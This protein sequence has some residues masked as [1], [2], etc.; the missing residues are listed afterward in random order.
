MDAMASRNDHTFGRRKLLT[1][2]AALGA[3]SLVG[4]PARVAAEPPPETTRLR[5]MKLPAIC[6]APEYLA[7]DLLGLEGFTDVQYVEFDQ[8]TADPLLTNK[9]DLGVVAPPLLLPDVDTGKPFVAL[10]PLHNGCYELFANDRV[11][12]I[13]DLKGKRVAVSAMGSTG[14]Y[15]VA[16]IV[17]Y[18]GMNPRKDIE[19]VDAKGYDGMMQHFIDGKVDAFLA[20]PPQPQHLRARNIG[21]V[22]LNTTQDRPWDQ[23]FC[24]MVG[25]TKDFV[26]R[27]PIATRRAIRAILKAADIC[28]RE[29]DRAAGHM[30][31]KGYEARYDVALEVI[32]SLSYNR[33][34]TYDPDNTLRFFGVRLHETGLIKTSPQKLIAQATD[35]QFLNQLK[36]E[37]KS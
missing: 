37:L 18:V 35:W 21:R 25:A 5:F 12:T 27:N 9:A 8:N 33:W 14:Y 20:F 15:F 28:A 10:A 22:I 26:A 23:Y 16:A 6:F 1:G 34:R 3:A 36:K 11:R 29:P 4:V 19:W 30:V 17:A 7:E 24:C 13:L 31:A 32:K 2:A